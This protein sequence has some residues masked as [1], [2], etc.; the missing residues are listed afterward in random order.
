M[1]RCSYH[2]VT[3]LWGGANS[4][5]S[6]PLAASWPFTL[7]CTEFRGGPDATPNMQLY[8][9]DLLHEK[10]QGQ[11]GLIC[12]WR[13]SCLLRTVLAHLAKQSPQWLFARLPASS[14]ASA[15]AAMFCVASSTPNVY[16]G[17]TGGSTRLL[18]QRGPPIPPPS[19][20]SPKQSATQLQDKTC[21]A[22]T[23]GRCHRHSPFCRPCRA[24]IAW[25]PTKQCRAQAHHLSNSWHQRSRRQLPSMAA[26]TIANSDHDHETPATCHD[27]ESRY[28]T[29][30]SSV[31]SM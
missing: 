2:A 17:A 13:C 5:V 7:R 1:Q 24:P 30:R 11:R 10:R 22:A 31:C 4:R 27:Q 28:L 3:L 8:S 6:G 14:C 21:K 20:A 16:S 15:K 23:D 18:P 12:T 29:G 26:I 9:V 25:L 19:L